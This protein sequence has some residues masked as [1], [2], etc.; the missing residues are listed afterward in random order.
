MSQDLIRSEHALLPQTKEHYSAD[1]GI[2]DAG[3]ARSR[4]TTVWTLEQPVLNASAHAARL[5][6]ACFAAASKYVEV[7]QSMSLGLIGTL[8]SAPKD[9]MSL[10]IRPLRFKLMQFSA[11]RS[12]GTKGEYVVNVEEGFLRSR[13]AKPEHEGQLHF[14]WHASGNEETFQTEVQNFMPRL[15]GRQAFWLAR[16]FYKCTQVVMHSIVM[17]RYHAW[18][19]RNRAQ[20]L[21]EGASNPTVPIV[22]HKPAHAEVL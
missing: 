9:R 3:I 10:Y 7:I 15:V 11:L 13:W 22:T 18:V 17:W 6:A 19:K 2:T 16:L 8:S 21:L 1:A 5:D 14:Q 4:E 12:S 20:L